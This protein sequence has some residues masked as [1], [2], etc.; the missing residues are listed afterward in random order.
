M[1]LNKEEKEGKEET[2]DLSKTVPITAE[3]EVKLGAF[4]DKLKL[5]IKGDEEM[6]AIF[7]NTIDKWSN[8]IEAKH[9]K[10]E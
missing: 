3:E 8:E 10:N 5:N 6:K 9:K 7:G 4:L 2:L 1:E